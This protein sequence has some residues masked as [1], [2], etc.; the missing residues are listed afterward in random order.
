[1]YIS[2][3][4]KIICIKGREKELLALAETIKLKVKN[5]LNDGIHRDTYGPSHMDIKIEVSR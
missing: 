1:M 3:G 2:V 4:Q 5:D